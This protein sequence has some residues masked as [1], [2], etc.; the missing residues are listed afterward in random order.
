M[1]TVAA[2]TLAPL[3]DASPFRSAASNQRLP[4]GFSTLGCPDWSWTK[5]LDFAQ[6]HG[7]LGVELRGIQGNMDLPSCPELG[8]DRIARSMKDVA[9]RGLLLSSVDSGSLMHETD[10]EKRKAQLADA[11]RFI[12]LASRLQVPYVRVFGNQIVG[13]PEDA[14]TH[15]ASALRELGDYA[16]SK[17]VTV[18]LESHG[19][20]IRSPMLRE[21][22][23]KADSPAVALL[24]D[25]HHTF[26]AGGEEPE[27]TVQHLGKYIRHTHLKDSV[28][29]GDQVHYVLTG[30][31]DVP[32]KRQVQCL[33]DIGY[34][35]YFSY[36]WEKAWHPEL[37]D[38]AVAFPQ[39]ANVMT[40]YLREAYAS[41][42]RHAR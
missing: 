7:F 42:G 14:V 28:G 1:G 32:V 35:G 2:A 10:P 15:V 3:A 39:Y 36:E 12:D 41:K 19:D 26:V 34:K 18:L 30:T 4:L 8:P 6:Q 16:G 20:F 21:I 31:G 24:W 5:L 38:P 40:G 23:E 13:T 22:L 27:F 17:K 9:D 25:A 11:R 33:V 29:K 37:Q